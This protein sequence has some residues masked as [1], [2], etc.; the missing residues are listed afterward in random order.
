MNPCELG[1]RVAKWD[2]GV[3]HMR[4]TRLLPFL[5]LVALVT[6][7]IATPSGTNAASRSATGARLL[8][9]PGEV[10]TL[11]ADGHVVTVTA[12]GAR[13]N[14]SYWHY[15]WNPVHRSVRLLERKWCGSGHG[16]ILSQGIAGGRLAWVRYDAGNYTTAYLVT[17]TVHRPRPA[18]RL[19][20]DKVRNSDSLE[21]D[22]VGNVHGDGSLLVFNTWSVCEAYSEG[23]GGGSCP[24]G[25]PPGYHV[26]NENI[27]RVVGRKKRLVL[28]SP[29]EAT[30]L[31]VAAGRI[32]VRLA[33]G[34]LE[35]LRKDGSLARAF[36]FGEKEVRGAALDV[37]E[38]V[39]LDRSRRLTWRVYDPVSGELKREF[40]AEPGATQLDVEHGL[41]AY[42]VGRVVHVLRLSDGRQARFTTPVGTEYPLAEIEAPGLFYSY[43]VRHEG[44]VRF[45]PL[46]EIRF[47]R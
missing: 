41:L 16:G 32:L 43:Q 35:L 31:S 6:L 30:V 14:D 18:M 38:L 8:R 24:E 22:S 15:A 23:G 9:V 39:V 27:W 4:G 5:G 26:Y 45:V 7:G 13:E 47:R 25:T 20:G 46:K 33:D 36:Q 28:A 11:A 12:C 1:D 40:G 29:D 37:S 17:A 19:T 44:R 42:I 10:T 21:G 3:R 34:S 2:Y